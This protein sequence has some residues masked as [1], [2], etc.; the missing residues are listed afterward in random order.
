MVRSHKG[1]QRGAAFGACAMALAACAQIAGFSGVQYEPGRTG[2]RCFAKTDCFSCLCSPEGTCLDPAFACDDLR[3]CE[4]GEDCKNGVC[5]GGTCQPTSCG[6]HV[7]NGNETDIDCGGATC[8]PCE[9]NKMCNM[10]SDC[11]SCECGMTCLPGPGCPAPT[12]C[13]GTGCADITM[14]PKNCGSCGHVC[15]FDVYWACSG[16]ICKPGC[17]DGPPCQPGVFCCAN[18]CTCNFLGCCPPQ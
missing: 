9:A 12:T 1:W 5:A 18:L 7:K 17:G 2:D 3:P 16:G 10:P 6:D 4:S 15:P 13:C 11:A 14:D 8:N